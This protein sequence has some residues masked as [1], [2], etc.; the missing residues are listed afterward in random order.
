MEPDLKFTAKAAAILTP[1][2]WDSVVRQLG[3]VNDTKV[4][5]TMSVFVDPSLP[6]G[7]VYFVRKTYN[8]FIDSGGEIHGG[9]DPEGRI[10]T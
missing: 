3:D 4:K 7:Y 1:Q 2:Q 9:I 8:G 6:D 10:S 5:R